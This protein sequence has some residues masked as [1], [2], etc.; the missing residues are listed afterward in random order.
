MKKT[1]PMK[2]YDQDKKKC[3]FLTK[4]FVKLVIQRRV[5]H[6]WKKGSNLNKISPHGSSCPFTVIGDFNPILLK[7]IVKN[8]TTTPT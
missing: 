1:D 5:W 7:E 2:S 4:S 3:N 8:Q 6:T